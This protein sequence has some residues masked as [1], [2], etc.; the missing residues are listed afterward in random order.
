MILRQGIIALFLISSFSIIS[1]CQRDDHCPPNYVCSS[2]RYSC[3]PRPNTLGGLCSKNSDCNLMQGS[4]CQA[5]VCTCTHGKD[6]V[7]GS[8]VDHE[9]STVEVMLLCVGVPLV[10]SMVVAYTAYKIIKR[11]RKVKPRIRMSHWVLPVHD[12]AKL[13]SLD[14]SNCKKLS[15]DFHANDGSMV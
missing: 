12:V 6:A 4:V 13:H 1:C 9:K 2:I 8:C 10:A 7:H 5:G 11:Q 3:H 15:C 14:Q